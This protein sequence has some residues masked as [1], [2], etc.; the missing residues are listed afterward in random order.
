MDT[1]LEKHFDQIVFKKKNEV[2]NKE[3]LQER[4]QKQL[5]WHTTHGTSPGSPRPST[6]HCREKQALSEKLIFALTTSIF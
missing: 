1:S 6:E 3:N 5:E 4:L 2:R